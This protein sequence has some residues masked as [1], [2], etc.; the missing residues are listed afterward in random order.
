MGDR[1]GR[2][3]AIPTAMRA[4]PCAWAWVSLPGCPGGCR[5]GGAHREEVSI[6]ASGTSRSRV[7]E[8]F[9]KGEAT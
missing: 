6:G 1:G 4:R 9:G 3:G 5:S 2:Y 7:G 8:T